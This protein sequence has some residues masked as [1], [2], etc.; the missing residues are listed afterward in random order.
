MDA[1]LFFFF[2]FNGFSPEESS[3]LWKNRLQF[4]SSLCYSGQ[5]GLGLIAHKGMSGVSGYSR[6]LLGPW[7]WATAY[8]T[9]QHL[10]HPVILWT[11]RDTTMWVNKWYYIHGFWGTGWWLWSFELSLVRGWR[12]KRHYRCVLHVALWGFAHRFSLKTNKKQQQKK[13]DGN[14]WFYQLY[15]DPEFI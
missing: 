1:F 4:F 10:R 7:S 14:L 11:I 9:A 6:H 13:H 3:L 5:I 12:W 8:S 15:A 2:F